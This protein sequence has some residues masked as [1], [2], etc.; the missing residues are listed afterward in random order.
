M[1][2]RRRPKHVGELAAR[3]HERGEGECVAV[4]HPLELGDARCEVALDR[5][6]RH[7]DDRV[8]EHDH[9]QPEGDRP[10]RPPLAVL[11]CEYALRASSRPLTWLAPAKLPDDGADG[12]TAHGRVHLGAGREHARAGERRPPH[13]ASTGS[14]SYWELVAR[15]PEDP[16]WFWP[17]A[18]EDMGL[19]FSRPWDAVV[20]LSR[21]P[22]WTTWFVGG[23]VNIALEL[24]APLGGTPAGGGGIGRA[25]RGRLAA[26]ADVRR[27]LA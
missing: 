6:Q 19:E 21:G 2:I 17:A 1:K 4:D 3:E 22:E 27:A 7:E 16:E 15:S 23:K 18:I 26:R 11:L 14:R 10:Q 25:G 12:S 8:V 9:E 5:G 20:D 13:A 24:R